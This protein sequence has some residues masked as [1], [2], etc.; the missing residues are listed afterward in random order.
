VISSNFNELGLR[1]NANPLQFHNGKYIL[2]HSCLKPLKTIENK[3]KSPELMKFLAPIRQDSQEFSLVD[4]IL[5]TSTFRYH[6]VC[7]QRKFQFL[8]YSSQARNVLK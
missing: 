7:K 4:K 3:L 5:R 6:N 2:G 8:S 1:K